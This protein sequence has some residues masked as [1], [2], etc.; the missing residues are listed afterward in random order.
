MQDI[1]GW[2]LITLFVGALVGALIV[3]SGKRFRF[4]VGAQG[5]EMQSGAVRY[6]P[7]PE[8][9]NFQQWLDVRIKTLNHRLPQQMDNL[10]DVTP[11]NQMV[12]AIHISHEWIVQQL[13]GY[14]NGRYHGL[15]IRI[16]HKECCNVVNKHDPRLVDAQPWGWNRRQGNGAV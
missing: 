13:P 5:V 14:N 9:L 8:E 4:K 1:A 7:I 3:S 2:L 15:P 11:A 16:W 6:D 12:L 10:G